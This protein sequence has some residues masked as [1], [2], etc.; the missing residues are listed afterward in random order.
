MPTI[1]I[2]DWPAEMC[3]RNADFGYMHASVAG[4]TYF[5][6]RPDGNTLAIPK[7]MM[8]DASG[9]QRR[10]GIVEVI[11]FAIEPNNFIR[12]PD[13]AWALDRPPG[14]A[15]LSGNVNW[16]SGV[17]WADGANW[18]PVLSL[19]RD[20]NQGAV[21]LIVLNLPPNADV[22]RS[23]DMIGIGGRHYMVASDSSTSNS[24]QAQIKLVKGLEEN[25]SGS[26]FVEFPVKHLFKAQIPI[27][28]DRG[29]AQ[30]YDWKATMTEVFKSEYNGA[31]FEDAQFFP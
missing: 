20:Y 22:F 27:P 19:D 9:P 15:S 10:R 5:T 1:K 16:V 2:F 13:P 30:L 26:L 4:K 7:R 21:T 31:T 25:T 17:S 6:G 3:F 28:K 11:R 24:G 12:M 18:G 23:G 14:V 29:A 8:F